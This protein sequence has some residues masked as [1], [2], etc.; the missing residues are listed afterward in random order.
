M[1]EFK[2][3]LPSSV[4]ARL[5][6]EV[7]PLDRDSFAMN[8]LIEALD[9]RQHMASKLEASTGTRRGRPPRG[10]GGERRVYRSVGLAQL[11]WDLLDEAAR[12]SEVSVNDMI[13]TLV[14]SALRGKSSPS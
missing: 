14:I 5:L 13:E 8:A 7:P 9:R 4:L 3:N 12:S 6:A 2:I 10:E 11:T 1:P